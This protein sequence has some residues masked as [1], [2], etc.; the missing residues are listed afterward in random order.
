MRRSVAVAKS[1]SIAERRSCVRCLH[2][3]LC[4]VAHPLL[5]VIHLVVS[6]Y[7][8]NTPEQVA[9]KCLRYLDVTQLERYTRVDPSD[10]ESTA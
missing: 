1:Q 8:G 2:T 3:D 9:E 6:G 10:M 5:P 4:P 7:F